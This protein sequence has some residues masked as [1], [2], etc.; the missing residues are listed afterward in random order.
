LF[1]CLYRPT[2]N[3]QSATRGST[4][5]S[6]ACSTPL[7][8]NHDPVLHFDNTRC[9]PG[10]SSGFFSFCPGT[11]STLEDHLSSNNLNGNPVRVELSATHECFLDFL[12]QVRRGDFR[13]DCD[14]IRHTS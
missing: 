1:P 6:F 7:D 11:N 12:F 14:Q 3:S 4:A 8:V 10:R 13:I 2:P 5:I 9:R